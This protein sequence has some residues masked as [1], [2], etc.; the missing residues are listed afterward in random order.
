MKRAIWRRFPERKNIAKAKKFWEMSPGIIDRGEQVKL[1][2]SWYTEAGM[3]NKQT[4]TNQ[5]AF[6]LDMVT[7]PNGETIIRFGAFDGHGMLG[8]NVS[9]CVRDEF[10]RFLYGQY[11][12]DMKDWYMLDTRVMMKCKFDCL[13]SGSTCCFGIYNTTRNTGRMWNLGDSG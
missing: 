12:M 6:L 5:D 2:V 10:L 4:K 13:N 8:H 1:D 3:K 11:D 9:H 7:L